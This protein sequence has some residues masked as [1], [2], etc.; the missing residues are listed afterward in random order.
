M[1]LQVLAKNAAQNTVRRATLDP[2]TAAN[3]YIKDT[4]QHASRRATTCN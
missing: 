1:Q 2:Q 3:I 4:D